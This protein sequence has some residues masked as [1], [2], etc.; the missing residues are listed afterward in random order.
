L[1]QEVCREKLAN[2]E[3]DEGQ[4]TQLQRSMAAPEEVKVNV[5]TKGMIDFKNVHSN[6]FAAKKK[7]TTKEHKSS[8]RP[9]RWWI[10]VSSSGLG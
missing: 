5:E 9:R 1:E 7:R 8:C 2:L 10:R 3:L 6:G 4:L